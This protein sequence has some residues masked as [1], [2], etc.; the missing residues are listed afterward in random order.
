VS[1]A[2]QLR[3]RCNRTVSERCDELGLIFT[4]V[5]ANSTVLELAANAGHVLGELLGGG[6]EVIKHDQKT[7]DKV[8]GLH[9]VDSKGF[10]MFA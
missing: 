2:L 10:Y 8:F 4:S 6:K 9:Q 3:E 5:P 7:G 1:Y